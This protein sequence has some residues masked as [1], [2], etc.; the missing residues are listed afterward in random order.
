[1]RLVDARV[2]QRDRDAAAV[3]PR[4]VGDRAVTARRAELREESSV[5]DSDA[6]NAARTG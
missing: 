3:V 4:Q 6:G 5:S 2:E 1:M